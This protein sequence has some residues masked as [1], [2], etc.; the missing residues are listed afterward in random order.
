MI[1][2][3]IMHLIIEY[4]AIASYLGLDDMVPK[5]NL[6]IKGFAKVVDYILF[7]GL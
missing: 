7:A 5:R 1:Q 2:Q 4:D 6:A 3:S